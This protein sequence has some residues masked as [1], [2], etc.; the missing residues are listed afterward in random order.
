MGIE[1]IFNTSFDIFNTGF[2]MFNNYNDH[3]AYI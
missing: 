2:D 1:Y 3:L